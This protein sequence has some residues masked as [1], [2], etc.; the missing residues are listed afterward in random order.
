LQKAAKQIGARGGVSDVLSLTLPEHYLRIYA[1]QVTHGRGILMAKKQIGRWQ[2]ETDICK[3]AVLMARVGWATKGTV[4]CSA[5]PNWRQSLPAT[6]PSN[7]ATDVVEQFSLSRAFIDSACQR[8]PEAA[9]CLTIRPTISS[10]EK[11]V[12]SHAQFEHGA[13]DKPT[14]NILEM[15]LN[16]IYVEAHNDAV[17]MKAL[18]TKRWGGT[19]LGWEHYEGLI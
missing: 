4:R 9:P 8:W 14:L 18:L 2:Y 17:Q 13:M 1:I 6:T 3:T 19:V 12:S 5:E 7:H 11:I 15:N 16:R 10:L